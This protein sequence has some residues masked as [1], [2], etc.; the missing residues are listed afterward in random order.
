[1]SDQEKNCVVKYYYLHNKDQVFPTPP[2][3]QKNA[4]D[5]ADNLNAR[6]SNDMYHWVET[7]DGQLVEREDNNFFSIN[8]LSLQ[9]KIDL[10]TEIIAR[11]CDDEFIIDLRQDIQSEKE[12]EKHE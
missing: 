11:N 4:L 7:L 12:I 9:T 5:T 3:T 1:M 6:H 8:M 2:M 10:D